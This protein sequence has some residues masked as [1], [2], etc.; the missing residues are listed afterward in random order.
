[1]VLLALLA[2]GLLARSLAPTLV[3]DLVRLL[4][5]LWDAVLAAVLYVLLGISYV[6]FTVLTPLITLAQRI[7]AQNWDDLLGRLESVLT[8][9][10]ALA[11]EPGEAAVA[12]NDFN[13]VPTLRGVGI[14]MLVG[15][16]ALT[17]LLAFRRRR[18][19]VQQADEERESLLSRALIRQQLES[20]LQGRK[21]PSGRSPYLPLDG[22]DPRRVVRLLYRRLLGQAAA[23]GQVRPPRQT[24]RAYVGRL[25]MLW[26]GEGPALEALTEAYLAARYAPDPPT[27]QQVEAA[28]RAW[29]AIEAADARSESPSGPAGRGLGVA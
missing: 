26:P 20:L 25:R 28:R 16:L 14:A 4:R 12:A 9:L 24:P 3:G 27:P 5:P 1:V 8:E 2:G 15:G 23:R 19:Q 18:R 21:R 13:L 22:D 7:A 29:A 10:R 6:L 11:G 17:F